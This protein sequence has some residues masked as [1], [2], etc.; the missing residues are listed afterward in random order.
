MTDILKYF[1]HNLTGYS[2]GMGKQHTAKAF[3]NQAVAGAKSKWVLPEAGPVQP[4]LFS[5]AV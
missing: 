2:L 3:L 4:L 1:N 5:L